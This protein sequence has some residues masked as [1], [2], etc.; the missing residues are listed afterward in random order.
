[1]TLRFGRNYG[2]YL[3]RMSGSNGRQYLSAVIWFRRGDYLSYRYPS[4]RWF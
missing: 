3:R 1:M 4:M 2:I